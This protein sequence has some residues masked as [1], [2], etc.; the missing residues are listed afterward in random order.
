MTAPHYI[1]ETKSDMRG[2]KPGW[3][4]VEDDGNLSSGPFS[5]REECLN[6]GNQPKETT[7]SDSLSRPM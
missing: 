5:S 1:S 7:T 6:R 4:A 3:Y 2:I